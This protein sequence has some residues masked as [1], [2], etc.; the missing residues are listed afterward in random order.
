MDEGARDMWL[1]SHPGCE[2]RPI[3][4]S[5]SGLGLSDDDLD[6]ARQLAEFHRLLAAE[7]APRSQIRGLVLR[8]AGHWS[9]LGAIPRNGLA[10]VERR[11]LD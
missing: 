3:E 5:P 10:E 11:G 4:D 6:A 8:C 7:L 1:A 9:R 2:P